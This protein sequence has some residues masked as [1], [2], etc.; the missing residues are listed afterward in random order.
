MMSGFMVT[1]ECPK[2]QRAEGW[3]VWVAREGYPMGMCHRA[4]CG[5]VARLDATTAFNGTPRVKEPRHYTRPITA[6][7]N[8]HKAL[9]RGKF[10]ISPDEVDGYSIQDDR[11]L[12]GVYGPTGYNYRGTIAYSLSGATPKSLTYNEKPGQ[13]FIHYA[14]ALPFGGAVKSNLVIVE[15]WFSAE[16]V[17][18][19]GEAVGVAL[20]GSHLSQDMVTE[21]SGVA[22]KYGAK[23]WL[24]L[25]RDAHCKALGYL[26]K[27]REQF[28]GGLFCWTLSKDLKYE[29]TDRIRAALVDGRTN[30]LK[31]EEYGAASNF[32]PNKGQESV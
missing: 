11:F 16:K 5:Y 10:G 4:T 1:T 29:T 22:T 26:F 7:N 9:I 14:A 32:S 21:I 23:V 24:A 18:T 2:C 19:T 6:L 17:A 15:D 28:P 27:Y 8:E 31:D 13:P 25:D 3:S 20:N 30:F 12:L